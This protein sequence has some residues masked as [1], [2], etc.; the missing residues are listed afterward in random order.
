MNAPAM[1]NED[2]IP[3][4]NSGSSTEKVS[5]LNP[6]KR[7]NKRLPNKAVGKNN[8]QRIV[9]ISESFMA[10]RPCDA[11]SS[12]RWLLQKYVGSGSFVP[13]VFQNVHRSTALV[14]VV[15]INFVLDN[16]PNWEAAK[17]SCSDSTRG[18]CAGHGHVSISLYH[19][20]NVNL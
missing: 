18:D 7:P 19:T 1:N 11:G 6:N 15:S 8:I 17:D 14:C 5:I 2:M 12:I 9:L 13:P 16:Q 3:V 4:S 20:R 10:S